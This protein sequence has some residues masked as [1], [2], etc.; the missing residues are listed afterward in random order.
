MTAIDDKYMQLGGVAGFLGR[1]LTDEVVNP[2][3]IGHRKHFAGGSIYWHP[4]CGAHAIHGMIGE[5][6]GSLGWERSF[7]GYPL[8]DEGNTR[9][10]GKY[11]HFM[12]GSI[13]W[14]HETGAHAVPEPIKQKWGD[15]HWEYGP[16]GFPVSDV[17]ETLSGDKRQKFQGG[18]IGWNSQSG[19]Y[20]VSEPQKTEKLLRIFLVRFADVP[21]PPGYTRDF[22]HQLFFS[23]AVA[24]VNPEGGQIEGSIHDYFYGISDG[25]VRLRGVVE[26]WMDNPNRLTELVHWFDRQNLFVWDSI[27]SGGPNNI[28]SNVK[29]FLRQTYGA[30]G[31]DQARITKST[32]GR[33][34][35]IV[36]TVG[37]AVQS[38][39]F[40]LDNT[41]A[42]ATRA[43]VSD[44]N[45]AYQL[46]VNRTSSQLD[47]YYTIAPT[48]R[49]RLP[50][51]AGIVAPTLR[52]RGIRTIDDL[53]IEG[54]VPDALV[55]MNT[56]VWGGGA[57]RTMTHVKNELA[58]CGRLDLWDS[59]WDAWIGL[60]IASFQCCRE[61]PQP[62]PSPE[63][64]FSVATNA[65]LR[66]V[67]VNVIHHELGHALFGFPDLYAMHNGWW[68]QLDLMSGEVSTNFPLKLSAMM[69]EM[70]G[71]FN[72]TDL[73]RR[74]HYNIRL[75][76]LE[77]H[78]VAFR[79]QCG[80]MDSPE[81]IILE[82]RTRRDYSRI[83][84]T[85]IGNVLFA[86]RVD[87]KKRQALLMPD[88]EGD[89]RTSFIIR[90]SGDWGEAWGLSGFSNLTRY[91]PDL[92]NSLNH[93]GECW[94][95]FHNIYPLSDGSIE[96]NAAFVPED[97][98]RSYTQAVWRNGADEQLK[99]DF[100]HG[101]SGHVM[102]VN[103]SLPI[104]QG[105]RYN[106][107]L[108]LHPNWAPNGKVKGTYDLRVP[109]EGGRLY[110]T[111][112]LS[113][114]AAGSDGFVLRVIANGAVIRVLGEA[115][116]TLQRNIRTLIIDLSDYRG[117]TQSVTLEARAG[118]TAV[119]DWIYLLEAYLVPTSRPIFDFISSAAS[120][121]WRSNNGPVNFGERRA[122][123]AEEASRREY[124]FLQNGHL[125][126]G[127]TLFTHPA[128]RNDGYIE[129]AF[130][131]TLPTGNSV[132][133]A[134]IGFSEDRQAV[135]NG[136]RI[137][138]RFVPNSGGAG[139]LLV[140]SVLIQK[141]A[142]LGEIGLQNNPLTSIAALIPANLRG[143]SGQF[144]LRVE[145]AGSAAEN[146]VYWTMAR[147]TTD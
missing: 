23:N 121:S 107:V 98:I 99:H 41:P 64:T 22:Y 71:W 113:E 97:L 133:R 24:L 61:D 17:I 27:T 81:V 78:N 44:G 112:A 134:E 129:G 87:P 130:S 139:H 60:P 26:E 13:Y 37:E 138:V 52:A 75:D 137:S 143:M 58:A 126:G 80:P 62:I 38:F 146:W 108:S 66:W 67:P 3:G 91:G 30:E 20:L 82:N 111:V 132:F 90:R 34:I 128:P 93:L 51:L 84:P 105:V 95:E 33:T 53:K 89:R 136:A 102:L 72:I 74:S 100:F 28:P 68:T 21:N 4:S 109:S 76:P 12:G 9:N 94:W 96:F 39:S 117:T 70:G 104:E 63:G 124:A 14:T 123:A 135:N 32:D 10:G 18:V 106:H 145:A 54:R 35:T 25:Y 125:Y 141:K 56:D 1:S 142:A 147:L 2:D 115:S 42:N 122:P 50:L 73:P 5:K 131:L 119:K 46:S 140:P 57:K 83:P 88:R 36:T 103:R 47:V 19:V 65:R 48:A 92:G 59:E 40:V 116:L 120:A 31:L 45:T 6:W 86:Y 11:C 127:G 16:L 15:L 110:L 55:F 118:P 49:Q 69:Q 43:T 114:E 29:E 85:S 7:L 8:T 79:L 77:T 101:P 144:V